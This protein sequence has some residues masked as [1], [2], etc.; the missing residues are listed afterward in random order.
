[1]LGRERCSRRT[2]FCFHPRDRYE[3]VAVLEVIDHLAR[4]LED[5][6][7]PS[8]TEGVGLL[9]DF[10][11]L[12]LELLFSSKEGSP[13]IVFHGALLEQSLQCSFVFPEGH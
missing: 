1:M 2:C 12:G 9:D 8:F 5:K 6:S 3:K 4:A 10:Y 11:Q 13:Q 7:A